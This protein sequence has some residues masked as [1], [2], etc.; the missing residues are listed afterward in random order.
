[1][2]LMKCLIVLQSDYSAVHLFSTHKDTHTHTHIHTRA[3]THTTHACTHTH[4]YR[5]NTVVVVI[6]LDKAYKTVFACFS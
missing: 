5:Y 6:P 4:T 3:E 2:S 1:M